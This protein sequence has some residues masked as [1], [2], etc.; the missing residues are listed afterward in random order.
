MTA[1]FHTTV[2]GVHFPFPAMN[3]SG[4]AQTVDDL[5]ALLRSATGGIVLRTATVHPFLHPEFRTLHNPGFDKLLPLAR[6]LAAASDKPIVASVAGATIDEFAVLAR[7][8]SGDGVAM[9]ELNLADPW[10]AAALAPFEDPAVLRELLTAAVRASSVPVA[11]KLPERLPLAPGRLVDELAG[12]GVRVVVLHNDFAAFEKFHIDA[13]ERF[14]LIVFGAI[15]SGYDVTRALGK[16]AKAVQV[17][18][19][20]VAE[21]PGVF[22]RLEREMHKAQRE[23]G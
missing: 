12:A 6:E 17:G 7:A 18:A 15:Q 1:D 3:E 23:R 4:A 22:A 16:G 11:A 5:R 21:G 20:L 9:V 8:F 2:A 10:V 19:A 13:G 14:D